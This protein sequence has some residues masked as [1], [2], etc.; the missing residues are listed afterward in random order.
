MGHNLYASLWLVRFMASE[1]ELNDT[2][3]EMHV[4]ATVPDLYHI[5]VDL[6]A[7]QSLLQLISHDN[8]GLNPNSYP[9]PGLT[10]TLTSTTSWLIS[11]LYSP[12]CSL[13]AMITLVYTLTL[14]LILA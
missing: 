13:S 10:L 1:V 11:T 7:V 5:L 6:N 9:N 14:T 4:I 12:C 2:V 3:Q 8:T